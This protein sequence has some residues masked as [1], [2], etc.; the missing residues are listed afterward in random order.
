[1]SNLRHSG[2]DSLSEIPPP[3]DWAAPNDPSVSTLESGAEAPLASCQ[4]VARLL[5]ASQLGLVELDSDLQ[6]RSATPEALEL[7]ETTSHSVGSPLET[8]LPFDEVECSELLKKAKATGLDRATR[9]HQLFTTERGRCVVKILP[10]DLSSSSGVTL[11]FQP[12]V[13]LEAFE[14][15]R[16][17]LADIVENSP[18]F[19]GMANTEMNTIFI[20]RAGRKL[21]GI[22]EE[23]DVS[24]YPVSRWYDESSLGLVQEKLKDLRPGESASF[25][26]EV[27]DFH[28]DPIPVDQTVITHGAPENP[29]EIGFISTILRDKR[30]Q[31]AHE[32]KFEFLNQS[33]REIVRQI[34]GPVI[35]YRSDLSVE[36][37][38]AIGR[39]FLRQVETSAETG[40]PAVLETSLREAIE[41]GT[42]LDKRSL[43]SSIEVEMQG[44]SHHFI[45]NIAPLRR[46]KSEEPVGAILTLTDVTVLHILDEEKSDLIG[47]VSHELKTP[48]A[49][50]KLPLMLL[51]EGSF[52]DSPREARKLLESLSRE[53]DRMNRTVAGLLD[54][55][56]FESSENG[57]VSS[58]C[59][60]PE[61][62]RSVLAGLD[63]LRSEREVEIRVDTEH[64]PPTAEINENQIRVVFS[65]LIHNAIKHAGESS[66]VRVKAHPSHDREGF[67]V[68]TVSNQGEPI[69][70]KLQPRIFERF[71]K[72]PG[73]EAAGSGLGLFISRSFVEAHGGD[74]SVSSDDS[75]T[76]FSVVLPLAAGVA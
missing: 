2:R 28:G 62:V 23:S 32:Q 67:L 30:E 27:L 39:E 12:G 48:I 5:A 14:E 47:A 20:N 58:P 41:N 13:V 52:D 57:L 36:Y 46:A 70:R 64:C 42:V 35:V 11:L 60:L 76:S 34:P 50:M 18:Y 53:V 24:V 72:V 15:R 73:N 68:F 16:H 55:A 61:L 25:A 69:P 10:L 63:S 66:D 26:T 6:I 8:V 65:N 29:G 44:E 49:A 38:S 40:V 31:L 33:L 4:S 17:Q 59:S 21:L 45:P 7:L 75:E 56:R 3:L 9:Q 51:L 1:M 74:I 71:Y 43:K 22:P 19:V 54:L 37:A